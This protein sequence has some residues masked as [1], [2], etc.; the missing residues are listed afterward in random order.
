M[1]G[2]ECGEWV[3]GIDDAV[4][5]VGIAAAGDVIE[6]AAEGQVVAEEM[7]AFFELQVEGEVVG[8]AVGAGLADELLLVVEE[9]EG[10]SGAGFHRVGEFELMDYGQLEEREIS[11]GEEAVGSVPG[12]GAGL[13]G[14]EDRAVDVEVERLIGAGAGAGVGTH[15]HVA[16][17]KA[18]AERNLEGV[19]AVVA[20]VLEEEVAVGGASQRVVDEAAGAAAVEEFGFQIDGGGQ[21]LF[22]AEAPVEGTW[23]LEGAGVGGESP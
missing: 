3:G 19:V 13:L 18:V 10:E 1:A 12:I 21:F 6:A 14:A 7:E 22:E 15:D 5:Y 23:D 16:F 2:G 8:E 11:P 17:A 4:D 9:A 20:C